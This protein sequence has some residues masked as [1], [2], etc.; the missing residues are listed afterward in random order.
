MKSI[1][2]QNFLLILI[3]LII[4]LNYC[5]NAQ[6][7]EE[8]EEY[9]ELMPV[10][11]SDDEFY[12]KY[13]S[14]DENDDYEENMKDIL[15]ALSKRNMKKSREFAL[16]KHK[17]LWDIGFG[18]RANSFQ[19]SQF[20]KRAKSKSFMD[21]IYGKRGERISKSKNVGNFGRKQVNMLLEL[22]NE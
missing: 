7:S 9:M 17:A 22:M 8:T 14:K 3:L 15:L 12:I 16:N 10:D 20:R 18:K 2:L 19:D 21:A 4:N 1:I 6:T 11:D 5:L 13:L